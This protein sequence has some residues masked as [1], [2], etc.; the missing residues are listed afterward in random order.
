MLMATG[1]IASF[2]AQRGIGLITPAG[3]GSAGAVSDAVSL[4]PIMFHCIEIADGS[5]TIDEGVTV[6]FV[7]RL[8]LGKPEAF[9]VRQLLPNTQS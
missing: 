6:S 9:A 1:H 5:R 4:N 7:V 8:K 2:D 3:T